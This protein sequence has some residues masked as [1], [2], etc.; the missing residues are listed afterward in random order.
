MKEKILDNI[1]YMCSALIGLLSVIT[2]CCPVVTKN[3]VLAGGTLMPSSYNTFEFL[4]S[5]AGTDNAGAGLFGSIIGIV[6][7]IAG[8][9][10]LIYSVLVMLGNFGV[11]KLVKVSGLGNPEKTVSTVMVAHAVLVLFALIMYAV[12]CTRLSSDAEIYDLG[13]GMIALL[14]FD[15]LLAAGSK[16]DKFLKIDFKKFADKF[17]F[18]KKDKASEQTVSEGEAEVNAEA[19]AAE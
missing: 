14:V 11:G 5:F 2:V 16:W 18:K 10:L 15:I 4:S 6:I 3:L 13:G 9:A 19:T 1:K 17:R 12:T 7:L 8:V